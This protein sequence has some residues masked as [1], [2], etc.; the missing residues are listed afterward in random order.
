MFLF[1]PDGED[2]DDFMRKRGKA[3]FEALFERATPLSEFLIAEL[4]AQHPPTSA[5]GRAALVHAARPYLAQ[6]A[7]PGPASP[8]CA[9]VWPSSPACRKPSSATSC[10]ARSRV[11]ARRAI[12]AAHGARPDRRPSAAERRLRQAPSLVR[13]L[14]Q[15]LL[16]QP[17]MGRS[18]AVPEPDDGTAEGAALA[19]L[20]RFCGSGEHPLTTAGVMQHFAGSPHERV[21]T[22]VLVAAEDHRISDEQAAEHLKAGVLRYWEQAK[23]AGRP[24][25]TRGDEVPP[26]TPEE[27]ERLRQ[28]ELVRRAAAHEPTRGTRGG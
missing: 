27:T 3:A 7:R 15:G 2:P 9:G 8:S 18:V 17:A 5:E 24:V 16:L 19:A 13:E 23:R 22:D 20:A 10:A 1:L 25:A 28:L 6:L 21:L 26:V 4:S 14:I 12:S 11:H